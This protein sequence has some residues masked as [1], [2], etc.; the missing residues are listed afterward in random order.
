MLLLMGIFAA[1]LAAARA[2]ARQGFTEGIFINAAIMR[3][4]AQLNFNMHFTEEI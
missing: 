3:D 1:C 4:A 2:C